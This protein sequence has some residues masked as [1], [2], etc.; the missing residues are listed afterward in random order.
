MYYLI[1]PDAR[2]A[3]IADLKRD[4]ID[5][6]FTCAAARFANGAAARSRS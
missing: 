4:G 6:L 1:M 5:A 2:T 3:A